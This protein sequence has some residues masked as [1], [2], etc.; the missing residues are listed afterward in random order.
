[1]QHPDIVFYDFYGA[2][3]DPVEADKQSYLC[4]SF[5]CMRI[6]EMNANILQRTEPALSPRPH[7]TSTLCMYQSPLKL[8]HSD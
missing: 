2:W 6:C 5:N 7:Q 1:M 3:D 4:T 8:I